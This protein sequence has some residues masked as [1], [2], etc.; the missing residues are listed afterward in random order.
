[1]SESRVAR[2]RLHVEVQKWPL[3]TPLRITGYVISEVDLV[4]VT[5]EQDGRIGRGESAGVYYRHDDRPPLL[6]EQIERARASIEGG[7]DRDLLRGMVP[8]GGA[9][10]A[11]DCALWDLEAKLAA[12][13]VWQLIGLEKPRPLLTTFTCSAGE[14]AEMVAAAR[15]Y[16]NA[17]AIKLKLTGGPID[18]ERVLAVREAREDVWLGVD[19]NQGFDRNSLDRIMPVL[20]DSRVAL[21]EQPFPIGK[22]A[23]LDGFQSP[24]PLAADESV[25]SS[26]D[27]PALVG[28][29]RAV[30]IKLDK[31]GG[32]TEALRMV[33]ATRELGLT[34]MVGSMPGTS[35]AIAPAFLVGQLC[36]IVDLDAPIFLQQDRSIAASYEDGAIMCPPTLW[37]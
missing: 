3:R 5:L 14:P 18:G 4:V 26:A 12:R 10:N 27:I 30:N 8:A 7:A 13:P 35:L 1:V 23:W 25:Q 19:A 20:V 15:A 16:T 21:I 11:V 32:L 28:R 22:E 34:P 2:R 36:E 37:G 24:I 6:V 29:F 33:R 17:H 31:C 9:R